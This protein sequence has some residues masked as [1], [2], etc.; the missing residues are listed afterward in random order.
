MFSTQVLCKRDVYS[1]VTPQGTQKPT[2]KQGVLSNVQHVRSKKY[3]K[4]NCRKYLLQSK[5]KCPAIFPGTVQ[6]TVPLTLLG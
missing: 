4:K 2:L 6:L 3:M 5:Q 1:N